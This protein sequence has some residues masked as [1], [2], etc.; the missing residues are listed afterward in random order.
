MPTPLIAIKSDLAF[1]AVF[2]RE[3][4]QCKKALT[5]LLNDILDLHIIS[6]A[7][8]N[9][10]NLQ[11]YQ[12]DK[13]TEMDI[14][15]ITDQGHRIDIEIQLISLPGFQNRMV[16]YAGQL[17]DQALQTGEDYTILNTK[18][19]KVLSIA[20]FILFPH[21]PQIKN[22]YRFQEITTNSPTSSKSSSSK[23]PNSTPTNP[24]PT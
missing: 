4:D 15:V 18:K 8:V 23:C 14:E 2:G 16:Y 3:C 6:L 12:Q 1:R 13:K 5:A 7:Y 9:P 22:T 17:L 11:T 19:C 24:S 20:D 10:L 21:T